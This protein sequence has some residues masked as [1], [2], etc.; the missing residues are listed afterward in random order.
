M[1]RDPADE[2]KSV[3][4][5]QEYILLTYGKSWSGVWIRTLAHRGTLRY[6][7][8]GYGKTAPMLISLTSVDERF[9]PAEAD[10][11]THPKTP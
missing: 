3:A 5:T 10:D 6:M 1:A 9:Q 11:K 7:R 8:P 4:E 2:W